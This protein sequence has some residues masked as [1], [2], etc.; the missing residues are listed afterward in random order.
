MSQ[1]SPEGRK[2]P[3]PSDADERDVKRLRN[4]DMDGDGS[5]KD[6]MGQEW[7]SEQMSRMEKL[8]KE[9]LIQAALVFQHQSFCKRLGLNHQKVPTQ[10]MDRLETTWR[11]YE[12]IR[13]HV[14]WSM[15]QSGEKPPT[16]PNKPSS[17]LE[18]ITR[19]A[20]N[21]IPPKTMELPTPINLSITGDYIPILSTISPDKPEEVI[22]DQSQSQALVLDKS[23]VDPS[24]VKKEDSV[25]VQANQN[26]E[27]SITTKEIKDDQTQLPSEN[28][29]LP[30]SQTGLI[31][32]PPPIETQSQ[33]QPQTQVDGGL[34][35]SSLGL[36]E[37]TA[38]INGNSFDTTTASQPLPIPDS[39][40]NND[41]Q[42]QQNGNEI[43]ASLGLNTG[44][45]PSNSQHQ[46][47]G[48]QGQQQPPI[49]MEIDFASALNGVTTNGGLD[50]EADF[51]A[52]AGLFA[53][54]QPPTLPESQNGN[55][56]NNVN[57]DI[58]GL[59]KDDPAL[60]NGLE[61]L[62]GL[63]EGNNEVNQSTSVVNADNN[64]NLEIQKEQPSENPVQNQNNVQISN[65]Q[66]N[67]E[68]PT[69][70]AVSGGGPA[71]IHNESKINGTQMPP[72]VNNPPDQSRSSVQPTDQTQ[73]QTQV[74][75]QSQLSNPEKPQPQPESHSQ[76]QPQPETQP[77]LEPQS[78]SQVSF[79]QQFFQ[80]DFSLPD[81]STA[82]ADINQGFNVD[83]GG[84]GGEFGEIDMSDFNFTDA[85][86]EGMGMGGDEFER[87]MA[88]FG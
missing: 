14:E 13:R 6:G 15:A 12:G 9:V 75:P 20:S 16:S 51:S 77:Q 57:A 24:T 17:T 74:Q 53:S 84:G 61:G 54:E 35:Y 69:Q 22:I 42:N 88:E 26:G 10:M 5:M 25:P 7:V 31:Q 85:G 87:L 11:T 39:I 28:Q 76:S 59:V 30:I 68:N 3:R 67:T 18:A 19:L 82:N 58:S 65:E 1:P 29:V 81:T 79:D 83:G 71:D 55:G 66:P 78:Q 45:P 21:A 70:E 60:N 56:G 43:F 80:P 64:G 8:Y 49:P 50:G 46:Q 48:S 27:V 23:A 2:R 52:L 41:T 37:L 36:D 32:P 72:P 63:L 40:T 4:V 44:V 38:L 47:D 33:T 73:V 34:D 86:L 62:E